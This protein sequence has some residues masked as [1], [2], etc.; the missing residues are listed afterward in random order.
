L[1]LEH[2]RQWRAALILLHAQLQLVLLLLALHLVAL[3]LARARIVRPRN[4]RE[5]TKRNHKNETSHVR[6]DGFK[7]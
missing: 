4:R 7:F 6:L 5:G 3:D 2:S 1:L